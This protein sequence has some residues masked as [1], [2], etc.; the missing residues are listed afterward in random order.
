MNFFIGALL[1]EHPVPLAGNSNSNTASLIM[2][3]CFLLFFH[4]FNSNTRSSIKTCTHF[5][6]VMATPPLVELYVSSKGKPVLLCKGF[7]FNL[8]KRHERV[9]CWRCAVRSCAVSIQTDENDVQKVMKGQ[10]DLH[11]PDPERIAVIGFKQKVRDRVMKGTT[12]ITRI[13]GKKLEAANSS[14]VGTALTP[15]AKDAHG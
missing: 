3:F 7:V 15:S 8:N 10:H 12:T 13:H 9:K 5:F 14:S 6:L 2:M 1:M 11:L 4:F